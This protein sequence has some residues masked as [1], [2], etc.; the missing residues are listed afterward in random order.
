MVPALL[1][2]RPL[3]TGSPAPLVSLTADDG[4]WVRSPDFRGRPFVVVFLRDP[5]ASEAVLVALERAR[6]TLDAH[7]AALCVVHHTRDERWRAL[8]RDLGLS[9]PIVW[10]MLALTARQWRQSGLRPIVRDGWAVVDRDGRVFRHVRGAV[11]VEAIVAAV[12][13]VPAAAA[14][15]PVRRKAARAAAPS[16]PDVDWARAE[17][18][19]GDAT[20][21]VL[22]DVR[23][24]DEFDALHHPLA[25]NVPLDEL[26]QRVAEL[27]TKARVLCVCQTGGRALA[28]AAYLA[29]A[30]F[31]DVYNVRGGMS[32][33]P[34][35]A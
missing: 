15:A 26:P 5:A 22:L 31:T 33:W 6:A 32:A 25:R 20:P 16:A 12:A 34:G 13:A 29:S 7:D 27:N 4:T 30:G 18:L 23:T 35:R 1:R 17:A 8:R 24:R 10:D 9:F 19:I 28:A 21:Y 3:V 2:L 14:D 11:D